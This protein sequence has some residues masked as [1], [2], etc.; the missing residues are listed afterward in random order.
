MCG[1]SRPCTLPSPTPYSPHMLMNMPS[2]HGHRK[3]CVWLE[4]AAKRGL[5]VIDARS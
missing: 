5:N 2:M 3:R 4:Y 1:W